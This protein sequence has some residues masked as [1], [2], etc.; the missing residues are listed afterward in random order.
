M[1]VVVYYIDS[2]VRYMDGPRITITERLA[3]LSGAM[4][5]RVFLLFMFTLLLCWPYFSFV[6]TA[7]MQGLFAY[8]F[9]I[10]VV[11][12]GVLLVIS[13]IRERS[14]DTKNNG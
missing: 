8:L 5:F 10:W 2:T 1:E 13:S 11:L 6:R 3:R 7:S 4:A 12:I 9:V 14:T